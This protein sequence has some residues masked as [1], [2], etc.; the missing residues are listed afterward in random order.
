MTAGPAA[1]FPPPRRAASPSG[2]SP[3]ALISMARATR[4]SGTS[5]RWLPTSHPIRPAAMRSPTITMPAPTAPMSRLQFQPHSLAHSRGS[6]ISGLAIHAN[7]GKMRIG[8]FASI[9]TGAAVE[10]FGLENVTI[11][12][13]YGS[14]VGALA[15]ENF[16]S[17]ANA[18]AKGNVRGGNLDDVGGL[19]GLNTGI[20]RLSY[21][22]GSVIGGNAFVGGLVGGSAANNGPRISHSHSTP[23]VS[24]ASDAKVGGLV[25]NLIGSL[26]NSWASGVVSTGDD[27]GQDGPPASAGGLGG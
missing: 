5:P 20:I 8:L 1:C 18:F 10:N 7:H 23:E 3:A 13:S 9:G 15:S 17:I 16:G 6:A 27:D 21:T 2:I 22:T 11:R 4:W 24:G 25:G 19:V 26:I 14:D 12:G